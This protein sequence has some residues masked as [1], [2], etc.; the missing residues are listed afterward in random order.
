MINNTINQEQQKEEKDGN[1]MYSKYK[2]IL[3]KRMLMMIMIK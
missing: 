3:E 2:S 1:K